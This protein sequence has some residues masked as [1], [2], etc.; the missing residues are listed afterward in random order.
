MHQ[1][2]VIG[3]HPAQLQRILVTHRLVPLPDEGFYFL[4]LV[5][6]SDYYGFSRQHDHLVRPVKCLGRLPVEHLTLAGSVV[7]VRYIVLRAYHPGSPCGLLISHIIP[8]VGTK[9]GI[10]Y[11]H[12][13]HSGHLVRNGCVSRDIDFLPVIEC[14]HVPHAAPDIVIT[15]EPGFDRLDT[16]E[17]KIKPPVAF[18]R[19]RVSRPDDPAVFLPV[20]YQPDFVVVEVFVRHEDQ[21]GGKVIL[22]AGVRVDIDDMPRLRHDPD[23][24]LT[25]IKETHLPVPFDVHVHFFHFAGLHNAF[26]TGGQYRA[27]CEKKQY[28]KD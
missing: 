6:F 19:H 15:V 18:R 1:H 17:F 26:L 4:F 14:E 22:I 3:H 12:L 8:T 11:L 24:G 21:V 20:F 10:V 25:H 28:G 2:Q 9:K 13:A 23:A 16:H 7:V 5:H 27:S